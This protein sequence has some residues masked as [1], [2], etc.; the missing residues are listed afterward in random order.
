MEGWKEGWMEGRESGVEDCLQQ[1]KSPVIYFF[2]DNFLPLFVNYASKFDIIVPKTCKH[3]ESINFSYLLDVNAF[4]MTTSSLQISMSNRTRISFTMNGH[5]T[6]LV[7]MI[8]NLMT[9]IL[10]FLSWRNQD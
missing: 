5:G 10:S 3:E 4:W 9:W 2:R 1:S 8:S 7:L 6:V